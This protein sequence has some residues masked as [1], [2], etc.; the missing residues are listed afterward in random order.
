MAF[1]PSKIH[2]IDYEGKYHR[3]HA[4][5]QTHPSP[6]R[7]PL[8]FQA[9]ASKA[10]MTFGSKHAEGIFITAPTLEAAK[11]FTSAVRAKAVEL[12]RDPY[13]I[14]IFLGIMPIIGRTMEEAEEKF[15]AARKRVSIEGGLARFGNFTTVDLSGFP[16]DEEF[17]FEGK[18]YENSIQGVINNIKLVSEQKAWTPRSVG[19]RYAFA[20][21]NPR[22]VGTAETIADFFE[23]WWKEAD[24]D[25]F[26]VNCESTGSSAACSQQLLTRNT[27]VSSP[28]SLEDL[29][30]LLIPELQRRGI[31]W[32]D[33]PV[34]GGT[35][36]E[37]VYGNPGEK[38]LAAN[39]PGSK[40]RWSAT[41]KEVESK[42][43]ETEKSNSQVEEVKL[44]GTSTATVTVAAA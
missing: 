1:D 39:H 13:S 2:H 29:V 6:Q 11:K 32:D 34:P 3:M 15:E 25:G 41:S 7:T 44:N 27:D 40:F 26:N 38:L 8:L 17:N 35:A 12:G 37:N 21:S 28:S 5:H 22:P 23:K 42:E 19:E 16:I 24:I 20:G 10:G 9:G 30:E 18:H 43:P 31:Y 36:R 33:Y 14:K 4:T